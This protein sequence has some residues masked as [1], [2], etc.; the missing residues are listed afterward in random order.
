[1]SFHRG[2]VLDLPIK[3]NAEKIELTPEVSGKL[4]IICVCK[5]TLVHRRI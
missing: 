1:M 3:R 5:Q 4:E 2:E